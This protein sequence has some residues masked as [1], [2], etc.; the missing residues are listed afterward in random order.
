MV[1]GGHSANI[2]SVL[3]SSQI[4]K[5]D[6]SAVTN[7]PEIQEPRFQ[8][9]IATYQNDAFFVLG[10]SNEDGDVTSTVWYYE[11]REVFNLKNTSNMLKK[12]GILGCGIMKSDHHSGRPLLV[13]VGGYG[14]GQYDCEFLDFLKPGAQWQ[15]CSNSNFDIYFLCTFT[16]T[17]KSIHPFASV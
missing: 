17:V 13:A 10:G 2:G 12:R 11:D 1:I 16:S 9:C 3:N 4:V 5:V 7:G 6:G 14:T 15:L 8:H